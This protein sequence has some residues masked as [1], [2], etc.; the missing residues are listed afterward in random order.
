M[1]SADEIYGPITGLRHDNRLI[2]HI[3][4]SA[5]KMADQDWIRVIDATLSRG[6]AGPGQGQFCRPVPWPSGHGPANLTHA[7]GQL[8]PGPV[9]SG[10]GRP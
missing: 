3:P 10:Q 9:G 8:D 4:W 5:F 1:A 7:P 2:K 6:R